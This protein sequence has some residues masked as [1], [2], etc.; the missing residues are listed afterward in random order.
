[1]DSQLAKLRDDLTNMPNPADLAGDLGAHSRSGSYDTQYDPMPDLV[2]DM[3]SLASG[4]PPESESLDS[5][6]GYLM[7]ETYQAEQLRPDAGPWAKTVEPSKNLSPRAN[8]RFATPV[9]KQKR[10]TCR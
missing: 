7:G 9:G 2:A 1:V 4:S 10:G 8:D 3:S 6:D 5:M